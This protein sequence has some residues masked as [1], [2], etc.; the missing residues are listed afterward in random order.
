MNFVVSPV[1][2]VTFTFVSLDH[3]FF[4]P[5]PGSEVSRLF[6]LIVNKKY[7]AFQMKGQ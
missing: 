3:V 2:K 4:R 1:M 5:A 7:N 6:L